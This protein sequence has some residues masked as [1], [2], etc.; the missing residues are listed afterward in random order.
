VKYELITVKRVRG[1]YKVK[2]LEKQGKGQVLLTVLGRDKDWKI[3][4]RYEDPTPALLKV[5]KQA[6]FQFEGTGVTMPDG[7]EPD[8][9]N[10]KEK[11]KKEIVKT[12]KTLQE[13]IAE[14][15]KEEGI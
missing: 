5:L 7:Q 2:V 1:S 13:R 15:R 14:M 4:G 3:R 10:E 8:D 6:Q 11:E 9:T 12:E